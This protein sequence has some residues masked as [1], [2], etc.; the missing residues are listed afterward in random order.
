MGITDVYCYTIAIHMLPWR[1]P[2]FDVAQTETAV[3][4]EG[5]IFVRLPTHG[6]VHDLHFATLAA[7]GG[8][9]GSHHKLSKG[10]SRREP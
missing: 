2:F 5:S 1:L 10:F 9:E 3:I 4:M 7:V 8:I 6:P